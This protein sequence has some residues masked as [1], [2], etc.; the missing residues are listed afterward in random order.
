MQ[1]YPKNKALIGADES[2]RLEFKVAAHELSFHKDKR[3]D[4]A[5]GQPAGEN[6]RSKPVPDWFSKKLQGS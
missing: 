3:L 6:A 4:H 2:E 5:Q 1:V